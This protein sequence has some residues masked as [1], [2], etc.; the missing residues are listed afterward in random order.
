MKATY[1]DL[2]NTLLD[3]MVEKVGK[4]T[5]ITAEEA[6]RIFG[7]DSDVEVGDLGKPQLLQLAL[8]EAYAILADVTTQRPATPN[9]EQRRKK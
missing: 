4:D 6:R 5:V 8:F 3:E 1:S 2:T 9:R 7:G